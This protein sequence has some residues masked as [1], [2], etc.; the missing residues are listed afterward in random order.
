MPNDTADNV[1]QYH[2]ISACQQVIVYVGLQQK[3]I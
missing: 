3:R 1:R 2:I